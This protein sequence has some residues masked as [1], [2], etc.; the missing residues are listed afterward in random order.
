MC[1]DRG[2]GKCQQSC[3]GTFPIDN[4]LCCDGRQC[5]LK[6]GKSTNVLNTCPRDEICMKTVYNI[7]VH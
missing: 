1:E 3:G 4:G 5:C 6:C 7:F 2:D